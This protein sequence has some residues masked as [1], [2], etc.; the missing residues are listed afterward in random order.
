MLAITFVIVLIVVC[1][2]IDRPFLEDDPTV[3]LQYFVVKT[4]FITIDMYSTIAFW[5]IFAAT[6]YWFIFFK[7]QE[8][9]YCFLPELNSYKQNYV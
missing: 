6:G 8:R 4:F 3:R 5:F 7:L 9:V 1:M 2:L